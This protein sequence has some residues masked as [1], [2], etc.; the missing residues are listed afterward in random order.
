MT[1]IAGRKLDDLKG[2]DR[3]TGTRGLKERGPQWPRS[4]KTA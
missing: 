3:G 4:S 1:Y 2:Y